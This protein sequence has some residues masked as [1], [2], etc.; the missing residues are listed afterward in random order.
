MG[1]HFILSRGENNYSEASVLSC[2]S[3]VVLG[4]T[5]TIYFVYKID[6]FLMFYDT[7]ETYHFPLDL[8]LYKQLRVEM[9]NS[10]GES[11]KVFKFFIYLS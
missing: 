3:I 10:H 2:V 5:Y 7:V 6:F 4:Y 8:I 11:L 9:A 1:N